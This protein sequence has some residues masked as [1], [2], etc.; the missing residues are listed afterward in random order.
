[1]SQ[2]LSETHHECASDRRP[3]PKPRKH[4]QLWQA[5][6]AWYEI[7]EMRKRHLLRA[8]T[9]ERGKSN[10]DAQYEFDIIE[11]VNMMP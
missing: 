10:F 2:R 7:T 8:S 6:L 11:Q 5:Y 1:M 9:A 4:P 3:D